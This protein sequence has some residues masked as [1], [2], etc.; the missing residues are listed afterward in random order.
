MAAADFGFSFFGFFTTFSFLI[1]RRR[2]WIEELMVLVSIALEHLNC[3]R[4]MHAPMVTAL[5]CFLIHGTKL[6]K[7]WKMEL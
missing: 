1:L 5:Y 6:Y 3:C 2:S 4:I 7:F